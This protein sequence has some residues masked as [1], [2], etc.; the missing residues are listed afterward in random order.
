MAI[1]DFLIDS[2]HVEAW[3][4]DSAATGI[5]GDQYDNAASAA[6]ADYVFVGMPTRNANLP[7]AEPIQRKLQF[8]LSYHLPGSLAVWLDDRSPSGCPA[9]ARGIQHRQAAW[10]ITGNDT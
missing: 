4:E 3:A 1:V 7:L 8:D 2:I 6:G 5:D 10:I 9:M